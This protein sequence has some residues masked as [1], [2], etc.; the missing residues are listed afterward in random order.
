MD[1]SLK[2]KYINIALIIAIVLLIENIP[3][4]LFI[5]N[6]YI[7]ELFRITLAIGSIIYYFYYIKKE[8]LNK[9]ILKRL[10]YKDLSL[11][12]FLL[13]PFSNII[14]AFISSF[15]IKSPDIALLVLEI[16]LELAIATVEELLFRSLLLTSLENDFNKFKALIYSSVIFGLM[17]L[18]NISSIESIIPSLIQVLYT[19]GL[20]LALG[21]IYLKSKNILLSISLHFLFNYFNNTIPSLLFSFEW[22]NI[23]YI[24]NSIFAIAF[25]AYGIIIY[26]NY[27]E[28]SYASKNLDF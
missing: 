16:G 24:V 1:N 21:L 26:F 27:K 2:K 9:P 12:P 6:I 3:F 28:E 20:G 4:S 7:I 18:L 19:T 17:H 10:G 23:F 11:L 14:V 5:K 25:I 15:S 13:L 8:A 22:N